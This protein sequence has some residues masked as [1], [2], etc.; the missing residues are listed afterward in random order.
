MSQLYIYILF[1]CFSHYISLQDIE[2]SSLCYTLGPCCLP[3]LYI[4]MCLYSFQ[5][6]NF[7]LP[8]TPANPFHNHKFVLYVCVSSS[9]LLISSFI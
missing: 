3:I 7:S 5:T 2:Y 8:P 4:V 1:R 9:V 6:P